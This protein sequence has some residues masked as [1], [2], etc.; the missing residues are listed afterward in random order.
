MLGGLEEMESQTPRI[1]SW[2]DLGEHIVEMRKELL[3]QET[4]RQRLRAAMWTGSDSLTIY[5]AGYTVLAIA[6]LVLEL[7][8]EWKSFV[9]PVE[10]LRDICGTLSVGLIALAG[11]LLAVFTFVFGAITG[12]HGG[13]EVEQRLKELFGGNDLL[14]DDQDDSRLWLALWRLKHGYTE[15]SEHI[16]PR[17]E[18]AEGAVGHQVYLNS[19]SVVLPMRTACCVLPFVLIAALSLVEARF[20]GADANDAT[21]LQSNLSFI[22][23]MATLVALAQMFIFLVKT[24]GGLARRD[25]EED[26]RLSKIEPGRIKDYSNFCARLREAEVGLESLLGLGSPKEKVDSLVQK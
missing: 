14:I 10:T 16:P 20:L 9:A 18:K 13:G 8:P 6:L 5:V 26:R 3:T 19:L 1:N 17:F 22:L 25:R 24:I 12:S 21:I 15:R 11:I 23:V 7:H 2:D 4:W